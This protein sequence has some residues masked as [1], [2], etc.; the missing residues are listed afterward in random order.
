[1]YVRICSSSSIC[2]LSQ[3]SSEPLQYLKEACTFSIWATYVHN[4]RM[5]VVLSLSFQLRWWREPLGP[6]ADQSHY[7]V[8]Q[9]PHPHRW[10]PHPPALTALAE[11]GSRR[12]RWSRGLLL[13]NAARRTEVGR[14]LR[15]DRVDL[16]LYGRRRQV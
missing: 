4:I 11:G 3:R 14:P 12:G 13:C 8:G 9:A 15:Q 6:V 2:Q 10:A 7:R 5:Y 16:S 1:M